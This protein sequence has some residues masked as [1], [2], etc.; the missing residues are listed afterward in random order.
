LDAQLATTS[1]DLVDELGELISGDELPPLE[2]NGEPDHV[3]LGEFNDVEN[4]KAVLNT[5]ESLIASINLKLL[6]VAMVNEKLPDPVNL[7]G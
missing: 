4:L 1:T 2:T 5:V 6:I 7:G 3:P